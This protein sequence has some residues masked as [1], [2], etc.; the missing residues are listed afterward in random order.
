[1]SGLVWW[2]RVSD[3]P[4]ITLCDEAFHCGHFWTSEAQLDTVRQLRLSWGFS[5]TVILKYCIEVKAFNSMYTWGWQK[6]N[7]LLRRYPVRSQS[8]R[9]VD[10]LLVVDEKSPKVIRIYP[11]VTRIDCSTFK[12]RFK[13]FF[14]SSVQE[15]QEHTMKS[16]QWNLSPKELSIQNT[17]PHN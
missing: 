1:M 5:L 15:P 3:N 16:V 17:E 6:C 9:Q 7:H 8:F 2:G 13:F 4:K 14:L 10:L 11:L 12:L